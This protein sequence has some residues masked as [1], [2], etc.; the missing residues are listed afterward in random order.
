MSRSR[1]SSSILIVPIAATIGLFILLMI[2]YPDT[3][4][5]ASTRGLAIWW[6]VLFPS[7]LP[8]FI[9]SE[10]LLGFGIVHFIG[11][12]LDPI[13][14]PMFRIPGIGGFVVAMG[15]ASGYPVGA[16]LTTQLRMQRLI[17]REEGE[18][19]VAFTTSSDPIFLIGAVSIGFFGDASLAL[20][21]ALAHYGA[22]FIV[23]LLMRFHAP[24]APMT[25]IAAAVEPISSHGQTK[26]VRQIPVVVR[27]FWAMHEARQKDGRSLGTLLQEAVASSL[28]LMIVVGGLVVFFSVAM[29]LLS[30]I[31]VM[32]VW[33]AVLQG[34]LQI[35]QLPASLSSAF[36]GGIFEV[37]LGAKGA[38]AA[39]SAGTHAQ[40]V[41]A[42]WILSWGG[43]SVHAQ[44]VSIMN[45]CDLRYIPFFV[46]R[47][48]HS[49]LAAFAAFV[50]YPLLH[51]RK[52]QSLLPTWLSDLD[53]SII[54]TKVWDTAW[55]ATHIGLLAAF[56]IIIILSIGSAA[57]GLLRYFHRMGR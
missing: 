47:L 8:F 41:A 43:L 13:M 19:L 33:E 52:V 55:S 10:A 37:T 32:R 2:I 44:I 18:R 6:D 9:I 39:D 53:H 54:P 29:D 11:T 49:F 17:S 28:K 51:T 1:T 23:G 42:A 36:S 46:S 24:H 15:Y 38:G 7:L 26:R 27:A 40:V 31:G 57:V 25:P 20:T 22:A 56:A 30:V 35:V 12:L 5:S 50:L 45:Q 16:K 3:V 34:M 4:L 48:I 21:I 14:R